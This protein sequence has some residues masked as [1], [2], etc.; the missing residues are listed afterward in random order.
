MMAETSAGIASTKLPRVQPL[1]FRHLSQARV[2]ASRPTPASR[3]MPAASCVEQSVARRARTPYS[4]RP[5]CRRLPPADS[6][7]ARRGT[8][9]WRSTLPRA[10]RVGCRAWRPR[11]SRS[12]SRGRG[13]LLWRAVAAAALVAGCGAAPEGT[14]SS[15]AVLGEI[16][17]TI[18]VFFRGRYRTV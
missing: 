8:C 11:H 14:R 10:W 6:S 9:V 13:A 17:R 5:R 12:L 2:H 4:A 16:W 15:P 7:C 3:T 1:S 18:I